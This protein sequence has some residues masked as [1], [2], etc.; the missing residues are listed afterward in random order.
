LRGV[1]NVGNLFSDLFQTEAEIFDMAVGDLKKEEGLHALRE[2]IEQ[3][4]SLN[5][6]EIE[7]R[8]G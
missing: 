2:T 7:F 8:H 4:I 3:D 5:V 6:V 1:V